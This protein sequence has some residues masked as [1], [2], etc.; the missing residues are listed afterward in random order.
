M[1]SS[2]RSQS[3]SHFTGAERGPGLT[4]IPFSVVTCQERE[5]PAHG[6]LVCTHPLGRFSYNSSCTVSCQEGYL[7]SSTEATRCTSS[8]T[9]SASPPA[10]NGKSPGMVARGA[11]PGSSL[12]PQLLLKSN[13]ECFQALGRALF[14]VFNQTHPLS[15]YKWPRWLLLGMR[16]VCC[17]FEV[18]VS[19]DL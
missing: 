6:S 1:R 13:V 18:G 5:A 10:C 11:L 17:P 14:V 2:R 16:E 4:C 7:P 8:G 19:G 12:L 15:Q 3:P 9:W